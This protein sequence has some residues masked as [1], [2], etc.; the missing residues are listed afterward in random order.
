MTNPFT[1]DDITNMRTAQEIHAYT[2]RAIYT[3]AADPNV[4]DEY[5][6]VIP[7][8]TQYS[9]DCAF[10]DSAKSEDWRDNAD[11]ENIE[12]EIFLAFVAPTNGGKFTIV[13]RFGQDVINKT[14]EVVGVQDRGAF[15]YVAALRVASL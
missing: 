3:P 4:T 8:T 11:V 12:A 1:A 13:S 15:G 6:Q 10:V 9:G 7:P 5:G 2:D 14:F